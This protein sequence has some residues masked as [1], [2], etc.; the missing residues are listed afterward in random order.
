LGRALISRNHMPGL[1]ASSS[2]S[3]PTGID[4]IA[5]YCLTLCS[6]TN[7]RE[8]ASDHNTNATGYHLTT[9][10]SDLRDLIQTLQE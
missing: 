4:D 8:C 1:N 9:K 7:Q 10:L 5:M 2:H 3:M 6:G